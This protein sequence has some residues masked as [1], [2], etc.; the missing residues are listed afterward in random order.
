M[1]GFYPGP[2]LAQLRPIGWLLFNQFSI[3][4]GVSIAVL[5]AIFAI[6]SFQSVV[7]KV[8]SLTALVSADHLFLVLIGFIVSKLLHE[9]GHG[10]ACR[11]VGHECTEMG[12]LLLVLMPCLYCDVSDLWTERLRWKRVLVSLAGVFVELL[13]ATCCFWGWY[14]SLDGPW[15]RLLFSMMMITSLNTLF[16]N[17]NPLMRYDGYYALAD[18]TGVPNLAAVSKANLNRSVE[19]FFLRTEPT[20]QVGSADLWLKMYAF[21]SLVYRWF[22]LF[23]IG[24]A[25]WAFLSGYQLR[26]LGVL[27]VAWLAFSVSVPILIGVRRG[28]KKSFRQGIRLIRATVFLVLLLLVA[29]VICHWPFAE[30]IRGLAEIE[31]ANATRLYAPTDGLIVASRCDGDLVCEGDL[32][33][34]IA[35]DAWG[36]EKLTAVGKLAEVEARLKALQLADESTRTAGEQKFWSE[37]LVSWQRTHSEVDAKLKSLEIR[38][39][40]AGRLVVVRLA[41]IDPHQKDSLAVAEGC[42]SDRKNA[43]RHVQRGEELCYVA[44]EAKL[45]GK[46]MV[47]EDEVEQ[48]AVGYEVQVNVPQRMEPLVGAVTK[49]SLENER[50]LLRDLHQADRDQLDSISASYLVEFEFP[51]AP[52]I[53]PGSIQSAAVIGPTTNLIGWIQRWWRHTMW[54]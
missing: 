10:L 17:G 39:P 38:A 15:H 50:S 19:Y 48:L 49:V 11:H 35:S 7:A 32:L 4:I 6:F 12:V 41:Q 37:R 25:A 21:A 36:L 16:V 9:L 31:L 43:G 27:A 44:D 52:A 33:A 3:A 45:L 1:P 40:R 13:I 46:M 26:S 18:L 29:M 54:F 51:A 2:L 14:F 5:T 47:K 8:P 30:R 20:V 53:R 42:W 22:I 24:M 23:V 34:T 28:I